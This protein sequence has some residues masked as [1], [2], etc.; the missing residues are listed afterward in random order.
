M[1]PISL[2]PFILS[3]IA[4][5]EKTV[6]V[7]KD[8]TSKYKSAPL[9]LSLIQTEI[10]TILEA[11]KRL[12][13]ICCNDPDSISARFSSQIELV[14]TF[15]SAL[16]GCVTV[17]SCLENELSRVSKRSPFQEIK[18]TNNL[19]FM[20][21]ESSIKTQ[22]QHLGVKRGAIQLLL[23]SLQV[24]SMAT[25]H[26]KQ[27]ELSRLLKARMADTKSLRQQYPQV[28]PPSSILQDST[29]VGSSSTL[30]GVD[31]QSLL[32]ANERSFDQEVINSKA[33]R[34]TLLQYERAISQTNPRKAQAKGAD[35]SS[36][37]PG[38]AKPPHAHQTFVVG[39]E[40]IPRSNEG[41]VTKATNRGTEEQL[42]RTHD[43]TFD[44]QP[45]SEFII[46][47]PVSAP[48]HHKPV[49]AKSVSSN[50]RSTHQTSNA[51]DESPA[52][53]AYIGIERDEIIASS[54]AR[55]HLSA[56]ERDRLDAELLDAVLPHQISYEQIRTLLDRGAYV[57][58]QHPTNEHRY[59]L[60]ALCAWTRDATAVELLLRRGA[61]VNALGGCHGSALAAACS[62]GSE[63]VV[64]LLLRAGADPSVDAIRSFLSK[65]KVEGIEYSEARERAK[66]HDEGD[67]D[68][69]YSITA[70]MKGLPGAFLQSWD[71][72][73]NAEEGLV[74][75]LAEI[76]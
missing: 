33:Y 11:L 65:K 61:D 71:E 10:T 49:A 58:E 42:Q 15:D 41:L 45:L 16:T 56:Y 24:E 44:S 31:D 17:V 14:N 6:F 50:T 46:E 60:Q 21:A 52:D 47:L 62:V 68:S 74:E 40:Y 3:V 2:T 43:A 8:L 37:L 18:W 67:T 73:K 38:D 70:E 4:I 34:R 13:N 76:G 69:V 55:F 28:Q 25:V 54:S 1:D 20:L 19:K 26:Q 35:L 72:S 12:E 75:G 36:T 51:P 22:L 63:K 27:N 29:K 59:V 5:S 39:Q 53:E 7:I 9:T 57:N 64:D 48:V 32:S 66:T 30:N 23:Q